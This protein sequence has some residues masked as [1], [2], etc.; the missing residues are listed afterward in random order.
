VAAR[1]STEQTSPEGHHST[2]SVFPAA[3]A[4]VVQPIGYPSPLTAPLANTR[5][6]VDAYTSTEGERRWGERE[7]DWHR[8]PSPPY[9]R[10][11]EP[12]RLQRPPSLE[13]LREDVARSRPP[14]HLEDEITRLREENERLHHWLRVDS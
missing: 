5:M 1:A 14:I 2:H 6:D 7:R 13:R 4:Y 8:P 10:F 9:Q 12:L 11:G 3:N